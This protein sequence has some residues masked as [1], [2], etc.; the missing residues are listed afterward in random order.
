MPPGLPSVM[1]ATCGTQGAARHAAAPDRVAKRR[2]LPP[3]DAVPGDR[4]LTQ[5]GARQK[6]PLPNG[7]FRANGIRTT[8]PSH[9]CGPLSHLLR[10]RIA[11]RKRASSTLAAGVGWSPAR[12]P[13]SVAERCGVSATRA[14]RASMPR[15]ARG[16]FGALGDHRLMML[17]ARALRSRARVCCATAPPTSRRVRSELNADRVRR[18]AHWLSPRLRRRVVRASLGAGRASAQR[19]RPV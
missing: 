13:G 11:P 6:E 16:L 18:S 15:S 17:A 12:T 1:D 19:L 2:T 14:V 8:F 3:L 7:G 10:A 5:I 9:G 4:A